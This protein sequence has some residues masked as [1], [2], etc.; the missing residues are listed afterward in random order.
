MRVFHSAT[1]LRKPFA[2]GF[3][4][5][6]NRRLFG[7]KRNSIAD[8]YSRRP[9]RQMRGAHHL[10]QGMDG[11]GTVFDGIR[12][13]RLWLLHLWLHLVLLLV[14]WW[15]G[16]MPAPV[17]A[18]AHRTAAD[19]RRWQRRRREVVLEKY[20]NENNGSGGVKA[21]R[22]RERRRRRRGQTETTAEQ[23]QICS[24]IEEFRV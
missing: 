21:Q 9:H 19:G 15:F 7:H 14:L 24:S 6:Q 17:V 20:G 11:V 18:R 8:D 16:G 1:K 13:L 12:R 10:P 5:G 22:F 2:F 23:I 3:S 4:L